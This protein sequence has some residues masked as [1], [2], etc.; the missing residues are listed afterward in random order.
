MVKSKCITKLKCG[1]VGRKEKNIAA[2]QLLSFVV[3]FYFISLFFCIFTFNVTQFLT[4][5][6]V[7]TSSLS[8]IINTVV[9]TWY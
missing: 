4:F 1:D 2:K 6:R 3:S 8:K 9:Q 7:R 5:K